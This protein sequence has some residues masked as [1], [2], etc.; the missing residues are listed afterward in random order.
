MRF[1]EL[2]WRS[3]IRSHSGFSAADYIA[4]Q[5]SPPS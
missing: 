2:G 4:A 5:L 3:E 1:D